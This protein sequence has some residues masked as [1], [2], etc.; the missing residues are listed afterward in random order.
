MKGRGKQQ[1]EYG[2]YVSPN[3]AVR[4]VFANPVDGMCLYG[5]GDLMEGVVA[6]TSPKVFTAH[7]CSTRTLI[8]ATSDKPR[9]T[10]TAAEIHGLVDR[11]VPHRSRK[12][13]N[14]LERAVF[15][16]EVGKHAILDSLPALPAPVLPPEPEI[17]PKPV[18]PRSA[19][20]WARITQLWSGVI[21]HLAW[22]K[23]APASAA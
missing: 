3:G 21:R 6:G 17:A 15:F 23:P 14:R 11:M 7:L 8:A 19:T 4:T 18:E 22:W 1:L 2:V 20:A 13:S 5:Y 9:R 10:L 12:H 16:S